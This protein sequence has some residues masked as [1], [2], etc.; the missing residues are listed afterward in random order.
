MNVMLQIHPMIVVTTQH[1]RI[2]QAPSLAHLT[3]DM[4][5]TATLRMAKTVKVNVGYYTLCQTGV[6]CLHRSHQH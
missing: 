3:Q 1:V 4:Q 5:V 6:S 2:H